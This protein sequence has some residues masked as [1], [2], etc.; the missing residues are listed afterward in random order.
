L[1]AGK[2]LQGGKPL[3][4]AERVAKPYERDFPGATQRSRDVFNETKKGALS[5]GYAEGSGCSREAF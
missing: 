4:S 2:D 1:E 5:S 3:D